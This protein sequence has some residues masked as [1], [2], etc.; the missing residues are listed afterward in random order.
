[1][2]LKSLFLSEMLLIQLEGVTNELVHNNGYGFIFRGM[3]Y[4]WYL[5]YWHLWYVFLKPLH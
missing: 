4:D 1:M 2:S 3:Y 5:L